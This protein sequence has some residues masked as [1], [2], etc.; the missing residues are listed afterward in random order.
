ML[1][2]DQKFDKATL[3]LDGG[4][5]VD[6]VFE[7]CHVLISGLLPIHLQNPRFVD[8]TW[9]F[10]GPASNTINL[11]S[12]MYRAGARELIEATCNNIMGK[13]PKPPSTPAS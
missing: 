9:A 6:S 1:A 11:M 8:C 5:Y 2:K 12:D 3:S 10:T 7:R 13:G 4:T